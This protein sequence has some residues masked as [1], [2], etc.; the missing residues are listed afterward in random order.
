MQLYVLQP[1]QYSDKDNNEIHNH[2]RHTFSMKRFCHEDHPSENSFPSVYFY[3]LFIATGIVI[4]NSIKTK[5]IELTK[6]R[7]NVGKSDLECM[8]ISDLMCDYFPD[9]N[10]KTQV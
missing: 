6:R 7:R 8:H 2:F 1:K 10:Q 4:Y 5:M 9:K 3:K